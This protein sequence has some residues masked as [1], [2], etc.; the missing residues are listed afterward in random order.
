MGFTIHEI[1]TPIPPNAGIS[2]NCKCYT[3]SV[4]KSVYW[5]KT[6][7]ITG[8]FRFMAIDSLIYTIK[9]GIIKEFKSLKVLTLALTL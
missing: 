6:K 4:G 8:S 7:Q 2:I 9:K 3:L 5:G 1:I